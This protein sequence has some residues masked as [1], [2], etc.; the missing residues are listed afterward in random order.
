[1]TCFWDGIINQLRPEDYAKVGFNPPANAHELVVLLKH[2]NRKTPCVRWNGTTLTP[3]QLEENLEH[4]RDFNINSIHNG[5]D[6]SICD[7]FLLLVTDLFEI[8]IHHRYLGV[9]MMI[10]QPC[11][12]VEIGRVIKFT[13]DSGHFMSE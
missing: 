7:P 8:E 6:C 11:V 3:K 13:S 12:N 2:F 1:M 10:Y 4:I 9:H 5:Y